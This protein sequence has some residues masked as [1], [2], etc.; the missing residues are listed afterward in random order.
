MGS[1]VTHHSIEL[2]ERTDSYFLERLVENIRSGKGALYVNVKEVFSYLTENNYSIYIASNGLTE[3]LA[4]IVN[5]IIWIIWLL[6]HL[7]SSRLNRRIN[8]I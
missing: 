1:F 8:Q 6:K 5:Y 7:V 3:Y 2:R 4:M